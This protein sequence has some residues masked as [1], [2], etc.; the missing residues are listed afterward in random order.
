MVAFGGSGPLQA[1]HVAELLGMTTVIIPPDPG[2]V[3]AFGLLAVD[4]KTDYVTTSV[5]REDRTDCGV[6]NRGFD[7]LERRAADDLE[8]EGVLPHRRRIFRAVDLRYFGEA[9]EIAVPAPSGA[10]DAE[11]VRVMTKYFHAEHIARY[12]YSYE[13][14]QLCEIVNV[15]VSAVG[16]VDRPAVREAPVGR[17]DAPLAPVGTR[18]V[19]LEEGGFQPLA[20]YNRDGIRI[21]AELEGPCVVQEYGSTTAVPVGWGAMVDPRRNLILQANGQA[22]E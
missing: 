7:Q 14:E 18:E 15:R 4:L 10:I 16:L 13:G 8:A 19:W 11:A 9:Y 3:S 22:N 20:V 12:G 5:Q 2:N 1:P 21:G 6:L 17:S